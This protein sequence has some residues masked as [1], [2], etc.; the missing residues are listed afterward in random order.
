M[1]FDT[2]KIN[3][4][5]FTIDDLHELHEIFYQSVHTLGADYY[6]EAQCAAWAPA[7]L[8][9]Y[10][11]S[12]RLKQVKTTFA[13]IGT[14]KVGFISYRNDGYIDFLYILPEYARKGIAQELYDF[15]EVELLSKLLVSKLSADASYLAKPFFEKNGFRIIRKNT[16]K[17]RGEELINFSMEKRFD[18]FV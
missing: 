12:M 13:V 3:F 1:H 2:A 8:D 7:D 16:V 11:W 5:T 14:K 4:Q 9:T 10:Y 15:A 6:S 17:L 18:L